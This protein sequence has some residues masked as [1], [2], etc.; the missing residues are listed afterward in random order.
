MKS[1]VKN[2][3]NKNGKYSSGEFIDKREISLTDKDL[4]NFVGYA[5]NSVG[6]SSGKSFDYISSV[7]C[8]FDYEQHPKMPSDQMYYE[9]QMNLYKRVS[10]KDY[11]ISFFR[12]K[13]LS[14]Q[15]Y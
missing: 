11:D 7:K 12:N 1:Y 3:L 4:D 5:L 9:F 2:R 15:K 8:D 6:E 13:K 14:Y 10:G